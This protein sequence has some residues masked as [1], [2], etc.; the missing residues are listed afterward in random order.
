[1]AE[2]RRG[3]NEMIGFI[4]Y[5]RFGQAQH[6]FNIGYQYDHENARSPDWQYNGYRAIAGIQLNLPWEL[7]WATNVEYH[8]RY[9]ARSDRID[10]EPIALNSLSKDITPNLTATFQYLYDRNLSTVEEFK[11]RREVFAAGVTWRY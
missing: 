4:H 7:R 8:A 6:L 1:V 9:Y 5:I 10:H 11:I 2:K 3:P